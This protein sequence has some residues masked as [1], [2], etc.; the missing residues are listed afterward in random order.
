MRV[1]S[2]VRKFAPSVGAFVLVC[3]GAL[4]LLPQNDASKAS[5]DVTVVIVT[6]ALPEGT[7]SADVRD[8]LATRTIPAEAVVQGALTSV[9]QVP[10]GV[11]A[12]PLAEGQQLT[13]LSF[14]STRVAALGDGF[15]AVSVRLDSQ[16]WTGPA[17]VTGE[18]VDVYG[19]RTGATEILAA[20]ATVLDS[21]PVDGLAPRDDAIVTL[22][23]PRA[24]VE[25]V[26]IA[27]SEERLWLVGT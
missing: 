20:G 14:A 25:A 13:P 17:K 19:V 11:L 22:G 18:R 24:S 1:P 8:S 2:T 4:M 6:R 23:V 12:V 15:V 10:D 9:A 7:P 5:S 27:A 21:P 3:A 26:L 16:R